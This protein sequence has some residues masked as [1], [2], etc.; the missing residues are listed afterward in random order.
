MNGVFLRITYNI[1]LQI[2]IVILVHNY[3]KS[4]K[5][6]IL[7]T[8]LLQLNTFKHLAMIEQLTSL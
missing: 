5:D 6:R 3:F 8:V 1:I 4:I 7:Y 2:R